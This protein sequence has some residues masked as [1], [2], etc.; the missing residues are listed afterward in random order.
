MPFEAHWLSVS[1]LDLEV[2]NLDALLVDEDDRWLV[3]GNCQ[4]HVEVV[5]TPS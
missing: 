5:V 3:G 2:R 1:S 4:N